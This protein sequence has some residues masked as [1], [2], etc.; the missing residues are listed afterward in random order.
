MSDESGRLAVVTGASSGLGAAVADELLANGWTVIG[1]SRRD[2]ESADPR[3]RH[4]IADLSDVPRCELIARDRIA[5]VLGESRWRRVGLVN[6]AGTAGSM[7]PLPDIEPVQLSEVFAVD[8]I[9]PIF[10][11]G[12]A[13]A[14]TPPST[15]LRIVNVSTGAAVHALP[16][17]ADYGSAKAALRH[18]GRMLAAE[19]ASA[20][21]TGGPR[22]DAAILSYEPG[23]VDT[24]M[25]TAARS[26]DH[27]WYQM[28]KD[29]HAAGRLVAAR[30]PAR[31]IVAFLEGDGEPPFSERRFGGG[32]D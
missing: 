22:A 13:V 4:V 16:G 11:M 17:L 24:P 27:P 7:R 5:P 28:F 1:I 32:G 10:L 20:E 3:Y 31:E 29:L 23:V 2:V 26:V 19:F 25:Q 8:A 12:L 6:N 18:A 9:A 15:P 21:R 14:E 30:E